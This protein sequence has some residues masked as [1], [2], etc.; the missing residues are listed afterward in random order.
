M[1]KSAFECLG[2]LHLISRGV[3][4]GQ[5]PTIRYQLPKQTSSKLHMPFRY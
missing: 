5:L 2:G 4:G 1:S 3:S